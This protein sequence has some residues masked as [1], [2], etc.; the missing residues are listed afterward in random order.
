MFSF[1][2]MNW[3]GQPLVDYETVV[4]LIEGTTNRKGLRVKACLDENEYDVGIKIPEKAMNELQIH[5]DKEFPRWNYTIKPRSKA[6][7]LTSY[8]TG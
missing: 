5:W 7:K 8:S 6:K 3:K 2:S 4:N 1:I